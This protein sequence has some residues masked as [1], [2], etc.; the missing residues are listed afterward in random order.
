MIESLLRSHDRYQGCDWVKYRSTRYIGYMA[1]TLE[2]LYFMRNSER[3]NE[4]FGGENGKGCKSGMSLN[5]NV[6]QTL[7]RLYV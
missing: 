3:F 4:R 7:C 1:E 5:L 2:T 6:V